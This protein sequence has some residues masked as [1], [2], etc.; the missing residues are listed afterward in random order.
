MF[1]HTIKFKRFYLETLIWSEEDK[2]LKINYIDIL[3]SHFTGTEGDDG[4]I[5]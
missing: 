5:V 3:V 1:L 2:N 4:N